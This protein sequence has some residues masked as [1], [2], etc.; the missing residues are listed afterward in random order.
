MT[1][2]RPDGRVSLPAEIRRRHG[3]AD[4]GEVIV[5]DT[6][7]AV[8]LR[9]VHQVVARAQ[10]LSR[11]PLKDQTGSSVE[12]FLAERARAAVLDSSALLALVLDEPSA[13]RV[14]SVLDQFRM[15]VVNLAEIV[16]YYARNGAARRW[17]E[18]ATAARV[19]V[20]LIR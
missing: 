6:G 1:T 8:A 9:S 10:S 13:D 2:S 18:F 16:S 3:L 11:L 7:D 17:L 5:E 19:D 20:D 4:G 14:K 15:C 12:D